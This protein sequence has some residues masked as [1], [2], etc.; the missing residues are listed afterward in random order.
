MLPDLAAGDELLVD[1]R[2][3]RQQKP[4]IG[5]VVI[6]QRPDRSGI[7][8]VK[9]VTAV[10]END[11]YFLTGDNP[12]ASTDS[13]HFGPVGANHILGKVTSKFG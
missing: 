3:Y 6:A 13:R 12:H 8:I 11:R 2:A 9:R 4:Q 1:P 5:D 7:E 10:T